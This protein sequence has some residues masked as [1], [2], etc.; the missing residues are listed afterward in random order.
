MWA[1][2]AAAALAAL[3]APAWPWWAAVMVFAAW[4]ALRRPWLVLLAVVLLVGGRA[5]AS[6]AGLD[7]PLPERVAGVAQ[8]VA[9]PEL[10][11][12]GL[13]VVLRI[14]GR[15]YLASAPFD[16]A[17][18]LS[19]LLT[20][21]RVEVSGRPR[22][23][24]GAPEGWVR[25]R[26]LA[27]RLE[28]A[29]ARPVGGTAP[30]YRLANG[31]HRTITA[32][33]R[34]LGDSGASLYTGLV[35]GDD[36]AQSE[37]MQFRF[38][39]AGLTH[40]LAVSGQNVAFL[41]A[42]TTPL[43]R[44]FGPRARLGCSFALLIVFALVTRGEPSVLR[45]AVMAA[46]ALAAV[47]SGRVAPGLRV[48]AATAV[49]LLIA[50]PLLVH[51]LGFRL[52]LAAT[53]GL[54][55]FAGPLAERLPGPEWCRLP[56]AVTL[57]AQACTAPI[58]LT[59]TEGVPVAATPANLLAVPLA[60]GVMML[61]VTVGAVAGLVREPIAAVLQ[62]PARLLVTAI[63]RIAA[64]A[65]R[66]PLPVLGPGRLAL[67]VA[68]V[69]LGV[70]VR[71]LGGA[72]PES[73]AAHLDEEVDPA[74]RSDGSRPPSPSRPV[75]AVRLVLAVLGL[76]CA[77][78]ACWPVQP[79]S[80]RHDLVDGATLWVGSCGG[81]VLAI[82]AGAREHDLLEALWLAGVR[83]VDLVV[84]DGSSA[85]AR[86]AETVGEQ[87]PVRRTATTAATAPEGV[88]P[89]GASVVTVGG[90]RLQA[91]RERLPG[92][93]GPGAGAGPRRGFEVSEAPCSF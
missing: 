18:P 8:L 26:H 29:S 25:S 6:L 20:G 19:E 43:L 66:L 9:D 52:S 64:E 31:I 35:M 11:R 32:G 33:S 47:H 5:H 16:A 72:R 41:L 46:L 10:Q 4:C 27:G 34:S 92:E 90:L 53:S 61:G 69:A 60:G 22:P 88:E 13:Q 12:F 84:L 50:D 23:L 38:E 86:L 49:L 73:A 51:S 76:G 82:S 81:R 42:V 87:L 68:A 91:A 85:A 48:L 37:L 40:L 63:E 7:A 62:L 56:L 65:S 80:G 67:V 28:L 58:L 17:G 78:V 79:S 71:R 1:T 59:F 77:A 93:V 89:L 2:A 55:L 57:A 30:W 39:A 15:R 45:A 14:D 44:R 36:R 21:E 83:R 54:L 24:R 75:P 3:A 74:T 70:L